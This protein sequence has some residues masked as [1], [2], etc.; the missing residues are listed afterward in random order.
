MCLYSIW[1]E[2]LEYICKGREKFLET[3][4]KLTN[5]RRMVLIATKC[6]DERWLGNGYI[7][8]ARIGTPEYKRYLEEC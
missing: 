1:C 4:K 7:M 6:I 2:N 3:M 5:E 8:R